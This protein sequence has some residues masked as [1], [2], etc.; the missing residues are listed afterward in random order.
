[1]ELINKTTSFVVEIP[2]ESY[3]ALR[4]VKCL[5]CKSEISINLRYS[6]KPESIAQAR[7]FEDHHSKCL[8]DIK[9]Y[10]DRH[11]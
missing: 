1:M 5:R 9:I 6:H 8:K 4:T 11:I 3:P 2:Q 7:R 10:E